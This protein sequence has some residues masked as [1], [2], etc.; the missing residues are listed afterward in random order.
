MKQISF[1]VMMFTFAL[2]W[3]CPGSKLHFNM[4]GRFIIIRPRKQGDW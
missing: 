2:E 1:I 4:L 3:M